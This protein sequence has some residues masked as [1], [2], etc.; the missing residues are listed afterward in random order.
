MLEV[1]CSAACKKNS[2][3]ARSFEMGTH[4]HQLPTV[5]SIPATVFWS[6]LVWD[7]KAISGVWDCCQGGCGDEYWL[8]DSKQDCDPK[9]VAEIC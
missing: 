9:F 1:R 6:A 4:D 7:G 8:W 5:N 3:H 2:Q